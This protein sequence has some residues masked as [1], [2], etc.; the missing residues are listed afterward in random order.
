MYRVKQDED[1]LDTWFSSGL[2]PLS[3]LGWTG[4][5][6]EPV[7]VSFFK[8]LKNALFNMHIAGSLSSSSYGNRL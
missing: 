2:L 6:N 1:V 7:P 5:P 4:K 3:A 8:I